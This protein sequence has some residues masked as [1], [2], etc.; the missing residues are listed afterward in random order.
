LISA[1]NEDAATSVAEIIKPSVK[2]PVEKARNSFNEVAQAALE[3]LERTR[4]YAIEYMEAGWKLC[5]ISKGT[6]APKYEGWPTNPLALEEVGDHGLGVI[7]ALSATCAIDFDDLA[8]AQAWLAAKGIDIDDYLDSDEAVQIK[9]GRPNRASKSGR[10]NRAKL[11][12]RLPVDSPLLRTLKLKNPDGAMMIEFRCASVDGQGCQDVLP[13]TIHPD[14]NKPYTWAGAGDHQNLPHLPQAL[15][16]LWL[17]LDSAAPTEGPRHAAQDDSIVEGGRNDALYKL[18]G[19]LAGLRLSAD[20]IESALQVENAQKCSPPLAQD[21]VH[22]IAISASKTSKGAKWVFRAI[23]PTDSGPSCPAIPAH[24]PTHS[25][26][27]CPV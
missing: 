23:V 9:S 15:H 20:A 25:G 10:P 11:L 13:P 5:R 8:G 14:T 22:S 4:E 27:S 16:D 2:V 18:G 26:P 7:H 19:D 24:A 21:E 3:R 12:Y 17:E 1:H 6:K